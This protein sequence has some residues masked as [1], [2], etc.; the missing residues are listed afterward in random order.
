MAG[1]RPLLV[2]TLRTWYASISPALRWSGLLQETSGS[3]REGLSGLP[4][5]LP[6]GSQLP[7]R[8]EVLLP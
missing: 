1:R 8:L 4:W 2:S 5:E 3:A 6:L 7:I